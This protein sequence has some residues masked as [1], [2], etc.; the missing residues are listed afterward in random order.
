MSPQDSSVKAD[1]DLVCVIRGLKNRVWA[2]VREGLNLKTEETGL[3][4]PKPGAS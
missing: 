4:L 3:A 1:H 2:R